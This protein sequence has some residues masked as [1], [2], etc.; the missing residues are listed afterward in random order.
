VAAYLVRRL[1]LAA[2]LLLV[3]SYLTFVGVATQFSATCSSRYTPNTPYPPLAGSV[4]QASVLYWE[5]LKGVPSGRSFG[6]VCGAPITQDLG[7]AL[8]HT[9]ALLAMTLVMVLVLSLLFGVLAAARA[10]SGLDLAFRGFSYAAWAI[11]PFLLALVAQSVLIWLRSHAGFHVFPASGWP[12]SCGSAF[13]TC[14]V[15][16][17]LGV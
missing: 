9:G 14:S 10:G 16:Q 2:G 1:L 13:F 4:H 15:P 8:T 12:G 17:P 3:V 11:P 5:W 6:N 7:Q